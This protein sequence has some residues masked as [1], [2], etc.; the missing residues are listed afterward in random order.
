MEEENGGGG[1]EEGGRG[2]GGGDEEGGK[3]MR[4]GEVRRLRMEEREGLKRKEG[5]IGKEKVT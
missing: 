1:D 2:M 5:V 3:G 4:G